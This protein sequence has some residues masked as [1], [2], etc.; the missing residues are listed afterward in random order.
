ME[1]KKLTHLTTSGVHMV[2]VGDKPEVRRT[3]IARGRIHPK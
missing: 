3:A 1:D 2:E